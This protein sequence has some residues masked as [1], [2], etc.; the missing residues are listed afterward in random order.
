[1]LHSAVGLL[2]EGFRTVIVSDATEAPGLARDHGLARA[3]FLGVELVSARGV[4][5]E[6]KRSLD[7]LNM[8]ESGARIMPPVGT[9][10]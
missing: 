9:V 6:W 1:V 7:G 4:Y 5:Y 3:A 2:G 10:L 8:I